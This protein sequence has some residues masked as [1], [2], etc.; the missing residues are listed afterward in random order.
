M[1]QHALVE[2]PAWINW[3]V[4]GGGAALSWIQPIAG[5][6]AIVWGSLQIWAWT[7]NRKWRRHDNHRRD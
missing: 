3:I 2:S 4:I 5:L 6:V 7:I 1:S